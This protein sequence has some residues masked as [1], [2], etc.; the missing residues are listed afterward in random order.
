L[1]PDYQPVADGKAVLQQRG[2]QLAGLM[3]A[4]SAFL[5]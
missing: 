4:M 1:D 2:Q 3:A 5:R